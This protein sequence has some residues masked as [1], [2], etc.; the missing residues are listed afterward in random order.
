ML[1]LFHIANIGQVTRQTR[2]GRGD[3]MRRLTKK[4]LSTALIVGMLLPS[5]PVIDTYAAEGIE[6]NENSFPDENFR[7]YV[8][9][10]L[11]T[12]GDGTL[13]QAE[14]NGVKVVNVPNRSIQSLSGLEYFPNLQ[15]LYCGNNPL[16]ELDVSRNPA[17]MTLACD[18]VQL[19]ELDVRQNPALTSLACGNNPLTE[20]DVSQNLNLLL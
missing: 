8:K 4:L 14:C 7:E 9:T 6:I 16:T 3:S 19:T 18:N 15:I 11:D 1:Y 12:D 5:F 13:T 2:S 20:L 10:T 17:L